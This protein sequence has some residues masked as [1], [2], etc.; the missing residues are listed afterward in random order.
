[1]S[2]TANSEWGHCTARQGGGD[3]TRGVEEQLYGSYTT[4]GCSRVLLTLLLH[5]HTTNTSIY[6]QYYSGTRRKKKKNVYSRKVQSSRESWLTNLAKGYRNAL[7]ATVQS[8]RVHSF[9][10]NT[11]KR[12]F[13]YTTQQDARSTH[14]R[15]RDE[16]H[17]QPR[18]L[19]LYENSGGI[20]APANNTG[21]S[22]PAGT[23][24]IYPA[25]R[26]AA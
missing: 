10:Y 21:T 4:A 1:M 9:I 22:H 25:H 5:P 26:Y 14:V 7:T 6:I 15:I 23:G 2:I 17:P 11:H 20:N 24:T 3:K 12:W 18:C 13:I 19:S 16:L 8:K